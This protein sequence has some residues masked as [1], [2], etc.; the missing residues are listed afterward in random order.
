MKCRCLSLAIALLLSSTASVKAQ[1]ADTISVTAPMSG[2]AVLLELPK[3]RAQQVPDL[4]RA[5][6]TVTKITDGD[7]IRCAEYQ[8]GV[9]FLLIDAPERDQRPYGALATRALGQLL[10]V[11]T[12][13]RLEFDIE[14]ADRYGR[15]LA[16]IWREDGVLVN[17]E[18]ARGGYVL[19]LTYPPNVKYVDR[20][21]A[22]VEEA[23]AGKRGLW[24]G[25]AF[26]CTPKDHRAKKC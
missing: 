20:I 14:A 16:Y 5:E 18:L 8:K 23:R 11:G 4:A 7:T 26:E 6:C 19:S 21:R 22:A 3:P 9:R 10:P 15:R 1:A 25:S 17:E 2:G 13:V 24:S 12:S